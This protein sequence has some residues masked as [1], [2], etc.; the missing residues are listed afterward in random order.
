MPPPLSRRV[1]S[2]DDPVIVR[3]RELLAANPAAASLGQGAVW[4]APPE[5]A[6]AAAAAAAST[7]EASRYSDDLGLPGLRAALL[8]RAS[9]EGGLDAASYRAVVTAGANQAVAALALA[10]L[11]A[12]DVGLSFRPA[13]FN[14]TM[15]VQL[16]GGVAETGPCTAGWAPDLDWLEERLADAD[17][18]RPK[19][20]YVVNPGN[21]T[22]VTLPPPVVSRLVSLTAG[23]CWLILD[24]TY[25]DFAD[26]ENAAARPLA[27]PSAPHVIHVG[28]FS[29]AYGAAG[30][31]VGY[32]L[33]PAAPGADPLGRALLKIQDTVP[34]H[35]CV[36]SQR[37]AAAC[38][39]EGRRWVRRRVAG[40]APSRAA[41]RAALAPLGPRAVAGGDAI[42]L[43]A[44]LPPDCADDAAVAAWLAAAHGVCVVPGA[45]CGAPG[46]V[47]VAFGA[48][49]PGPAFDEAAAR[50]RR[51]CEELAEQGWGVVARWLEGRRGRR[52]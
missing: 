9:A 15:A 31:R 34:I 27:L 20:V 41:A 48:P 29:K 25:A 22:G 6:L 38:L 49:P 8:A 52:V 32:V 50:L 43:W 5:S 35:A 14:A 7:P 23:R 21:P 24:G 46:H 47:R 36:A 11:D 1:A 16:A 51:G 39:A 42:Y 13:Y 12:G 33:Y 45:A 30:W 17:K 3:M 18:S 40:L 19:F 4:W 37:L 28:S 2:V 10:T 44:A 26:S